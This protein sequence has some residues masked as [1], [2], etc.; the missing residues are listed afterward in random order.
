MDD[1]D[2]AFER[3]EKY[4]NNRLDVVLNAIRRG[5][6]DCGRYAHKIKIGK[7]VKEVKGWWL[8]DDDSKQ[9]KHEP[10]YRGNES[11]NS[12]K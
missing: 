11:V 5:T 12:G 1:I 2:I 10:E 9:Q 4:K 3:Y 6:L 8:K 7:P